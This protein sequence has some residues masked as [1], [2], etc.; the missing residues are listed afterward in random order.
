L[1]TLPGS[2]HL[3]EA[4]YRVEGGQVLFVWNDEEAQFYR[5]HR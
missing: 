1:S 4:V 2:G 3:E 5:F